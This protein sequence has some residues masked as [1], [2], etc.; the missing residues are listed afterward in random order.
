MMN[1][2]GNA[3]LKQKILFSLVIFSTLGIYVIGQI[4][5]LKSK[6]ALEQLSISQMESLAIARAASVEGTFAQSLDFTKEKTLDRWIEGLFLA[7]ESAFYGNGM[8][9][10][11]DES[12]YLDGYKNLDKNYLERT[13]NSISNQ[14]FDDLILISINGQVV[15][16]VKDA[17]N[18]PYLGKNVLNGVY[19]D[20]GLEK[21][22]SEANAST[23]KGKV[24]FS[25]YNVDPVTGKAGAYLKW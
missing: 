5:Y 6:S 18:S 22:F 12:I 13:S 15:M 1:W 10:G 14:R 9:P 16:V 19:K 4:S 8:S 7:Y 23:E 24:F 2:F 21:C 20:S 11:N 17:A 3:S 25:N